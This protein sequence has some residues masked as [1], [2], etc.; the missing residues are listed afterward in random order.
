MLEVSPAEAAHVRVHVR[1]CARACPREMQP[2]MLSTN[3]EP[4]SAVNPFPVSLMF[5]HVSD[6]FDWQLRTAPDWF[7]SVT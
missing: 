3:Q 5:V 2:I 1:A 4:V 7:L 6:P